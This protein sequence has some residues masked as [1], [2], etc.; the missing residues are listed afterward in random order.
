MDSRIEK[1]SRLQAAVSAYNDGR[2][3]SIRKCADAH[4]V[5]YATLHGRLKGAQSRVV[6]HSDQQ[7]LT[8]ETEILLVNWCLQLER[9]GDAPTHQSLNQMAALLSRLSG[10]AGQVGKNWTH[11][12]LQRHP[13]IHTKQGKSMDS[14]QV[15]GIN[16]ESIFQW[17]QELL[18]RIRNRS[19]K[20]ENILNMDEVGT[21]FSILGNQRVI[22]C[23]DTDSS[24][25]I[26]PLDRV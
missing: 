14:K 23:T 24:I 16:E 25:K 8:P 7:L 17:F 18:V 21:S 11:R 22:G 3:I 15:R 5:A 12:F 20:T 19:I 6:A 13:E 1:A 2:F 9:D 10:G 4:N 26:T